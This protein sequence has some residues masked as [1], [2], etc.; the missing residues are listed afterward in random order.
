LLSNPYFVPVGVVYNPERQHLSHS[1]RFKI[2]PTQV[3]T[4]NNC[5]EKANGK[6][7][8][9]VELP[10]VWGSH[11]HLDTIYPTNIHITQAG[12]EFY[13]VFGEITFPLTMDIEECPDRV[14]IKPVA[15]LAICPEVMLSIADALNK[16]ISVYL[17]QQAGQS[18]DSDG[19]A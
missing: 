8:W 6:Q 1:R 16:N 13:L 9:K 11:D 15:K 19:E 2:N 4:M 12:G 10:T 5:G 3:N 18:D 14:E 7:P 17:S